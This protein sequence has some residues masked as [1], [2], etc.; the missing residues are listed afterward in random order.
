M[1][2][3]TGVAMSYED[4]AAEEIPATAKVAVHMPE[5]GSVMSD[6]RDVLNDVL[7]SQQSPEAIIP[8]IQKWHDLRQAINNGENVGIALG[9]TGFQIVAFD[10]TGDLKQDA[11]QVNRS[12][13]G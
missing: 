10:L 1:L 13:K 7:N 8:T 6:L 5:I 9:S 4:D 11:G 3:P 12:K 2:Q